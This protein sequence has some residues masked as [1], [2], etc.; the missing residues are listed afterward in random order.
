M[1]QKMEVAGAMCYFSMLSISLFFTA[2]SLIGFGWYVLLFMQKGK[3]HHSMKM[4][5]QQMIERLLAGQ[6]QM[7]AKRI[8]DREEIK[9]ESMTDREHMQEMLAR[10]RRQSGK[11]Q[12]KSERRN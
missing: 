8:A 7:M 1:Q 4:E 6:E 12:H 9:K 10:T 3:K 11:D 2:C 5:M